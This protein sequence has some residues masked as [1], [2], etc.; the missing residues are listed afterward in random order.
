[1]TEKIFEAHIDSNGPD[2][3]H[4]Y[5]HNIFKA[6]PIYAAKKINRESENGEREKFPAKRKRKGSSIRAAN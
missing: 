1:M 6:R 2:P 4:L 3:I 5:H